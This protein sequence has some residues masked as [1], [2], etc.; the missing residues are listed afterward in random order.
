RGDADEENGGG[1]A[2]EE[3]KDGTLL[4]AQRHANADFVGA[5]CDYVGHHAVEAD[6]GEQERQA[7]EEARK[8]GIKCSCRT[9]S[10]ACCFNVLNSRDADLFTLAMAS[11]TAGISAPGVVAVRIS[12]VVSSRRL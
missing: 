8:D 5:Q 1:I 11:R 3:A 4:R 6:G 12:K 7:A 10:S 2:H 9:E